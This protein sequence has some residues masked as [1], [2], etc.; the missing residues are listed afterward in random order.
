MDRFDRQKYIEIAEAYE[1]TKSLA[2]TAKLIGLTKERV[3]QILVL[4]KE[5]GVIQYNPSEVPHE[6]IFKGLSKK[7]PKDK[8]IEFLK[9]FKNA[10]RAFK[11]MGINNSVG[12]A[13]L[14]HYGITRAD[15]QSD[16]SKSR[17]M[18][19]Y[20]DLFESKGHHPSATE[21]L[22]SKSGRVLYAAII[23][24]W[25]GIKQFRDTYGIK[26][27]GSHFVNKETL[28]R[29]LES[30][31]KAR[32]TGSEKVYGH[33]RDILRL[34]ESS[35]DFMNRNNIEKELSLSSASVVKYLNQLTAEEVVL[36]VPLGKEL[37]YKPNPTHDNY[38]LYL[39]EE[40]GAGEKA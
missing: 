33:K 25:G 29:F 23:K 10:L 20:M 22:E 16:R 4:G 9:Q 26:T 27:A 35:K 24:Y 34:L 30:K 13:F 14:K 18:K 19:Q 32:I 8:V 39:N 21:L 40:V 31:R 37:Y 38:A 5:K 36:V 7:F 1:K 15:Y 28:L 2:E 12:F 17:Y 6:E 11:E 3:R